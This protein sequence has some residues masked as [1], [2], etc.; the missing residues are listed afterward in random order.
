MCTSRFPGTLHAMPMGRSH[1]CL[2]LL[3]VFVL[4]LFALALV[5]QP[6][7]AAAGEL[8]ELAHDPTGGHQHALHADDVAKE[9]KAADEPGDGAA[10]LHTLLHF[11]H[12]CSACTAVLPA[13]KA[14]ALKPMR[15]DPLAISRARVPTQVRLPAPFKPPIFA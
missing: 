13:V 11:S 4:G 12:C 10:T 9:L 14:I 5:L 2:P 8:H 1:R 15:R 3:R 6:V 7:L